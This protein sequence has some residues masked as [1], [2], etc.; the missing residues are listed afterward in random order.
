[1]PLMNGDKF[2]QVIK[3]MHPGTPVVLLTGFAEMLTDSEFSGAVDIVLSK[4]VSPA[5]L[6]EAFE[7]VIPAAA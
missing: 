2:A 7:Q 5:K 6:R 3:R 1:M 4:P